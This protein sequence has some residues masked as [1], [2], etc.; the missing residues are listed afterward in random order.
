MIL[1][2]TQDLVAGLQA[3]DTAPDLDVQYLVVLEVDVMSVQTHAAAV[4]IEPGTDR[5]N[6][7][8]LALRLRVIGDLL[9]GRARGSG[10]LDPTSAED[11]AVPDFATLDLAPLPPLATDEGAAAETST[12]PRPGRRP[13]CHRLGRS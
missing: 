1:R 10:A 4:R 5:D 11:V 12:S 2:S 3:P 6:A 8:R 7:D 9:L 13:R